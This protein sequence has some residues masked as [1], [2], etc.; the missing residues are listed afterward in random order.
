MRLVPLKELPADEVTSNSTLLQQM[1]IPGVPILWIQKDVHHSPPYQWCSAF[2]SLSMDSSK[3]ASF[4]TSDIF[5]RGLFWGSNK[6]PKK[7]YKTCAVV[8]NSRGLLDSG[9]GSEIDSHEMVKIFFL[10]VKQFY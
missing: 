1:F 5:S 7:I 8:G 3:L 6:K 4:P 10:A 2:Q 9:K